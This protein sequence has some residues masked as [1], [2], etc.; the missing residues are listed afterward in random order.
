MNLVLIGY[1]GSGKTT[2]GRMLADERDCAFVDTD[3]LIAHRAGKSIADIFADDGEPVFRKQE[4]DAIKLATSQSGRVISVGGGAIESEKNRKTLRSYGTVVWLEAPAA[5]LWQRISGD[6]ATASQRPD[7]AGGG[8]QEVEAVLAR[9]AAWY[10]E[11][12]HFVVR[13]SDRTPRQV[14]SDIEEWLALQ[15]R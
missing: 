4:T 2:V 3:E 8:L 1:R 10:A 11:T 5:I 7:L 13:V 15:G 6:V 9:R 14:M 12:A